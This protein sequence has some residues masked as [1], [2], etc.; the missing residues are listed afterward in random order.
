MADVFISYKREDRASAE[1]LADLLEA[2]GFEVWW[3]FDLLGGQKFRNVIEQV[4]NK[5]PAAIVL[6]SRRSRDSDW[7]IDEATLAKRKHKLIPARIDDCDVPLEFGQL[8]TE[9]LSKWDGST[10]NENFLSL[11]RAV[12]ARTGKASKQIVDADARSAR[13]VEFEEF[14]RAQLSKSRAALEEFQ[15]RHPQGQLTEVVRHQLRAT[16]LDWR[17]VAGAIVA[18]LATLT[19]SVVIFG[20]ALGNRPQPESTERELTTATNSEAPLPADARPALDAINALRPEDWSTTSLQTLAN[21]ILTAAPVESLQEAARQGSA[22]AQF[23][24]AG[25]YQ[26]G[27]GGL[28]PSAAE[29]LDYLRRSAEQGFARAQNA[30]GLA[31]E[32]GETGERSL[33]EAARFYRL[34]ADQGNAIALFNLARLYRSGEGLPQDFAQALNLYMMSSQQDYG[35]AFVEL[36]LMHEGGEGVTRD[37]A[38]AVSYYQ[39]AVELNDGLALVKLALMYEAGR[40]GLR[41]DLVEAER[42]LERAEQQSEQIAANQAAENLQRIRASRQSR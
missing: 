11:V 19:A 34:A 18:T 4:I 6:W 16:G 29:Q 33:A 14:K 22:E 35:P 1:R 41:R 30:L 38:R 25:A 32:E 40:G 20:W 2:R 42:L 31:Y 12:E 13:V 27:L 10:S 23:I 36:G 37:D 8:H 21:R 9:D 7:V 5:C 15:Q 39:R 24:L 17:L 3:D 26:Y 28:Q